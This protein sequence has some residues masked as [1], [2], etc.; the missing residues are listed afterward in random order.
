[1]I[2]GK[3]VES[4][5]LFRNEVGNPGDLVITL[6]VHSLSYYLIFPSFFSCK[7][8]R[9]LGLYIYIYIYPI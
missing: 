7:F 2:F 3:K 8:F 9:L 4:S 6:L 5:S 1:M